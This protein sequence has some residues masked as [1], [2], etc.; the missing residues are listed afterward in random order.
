[1]KAMAVAAAGTLLVC[2]C[3]P[4]VP[5][6]ALQL[7]PMSLADR[8]IQTRRFATSDEGK[9]QRAVAQVMQDLAFQI[10]ES[11]TRLGVVMASRT[12]NA[13]DVASVVRAVLAGPLVRIPRLPERLQTIRASVVTRTMGSSEVAV[14]ITFQRVVRDRDGAPS[15]VEPVNDPALHQDFFERLSQSI[16]LTAEGL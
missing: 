16:F 9:I 6:A 4:V 1:M 5:P 14:R 13:S 11:E 10:D 2:G 15:T 8:Q 3:A 12:R 7:P